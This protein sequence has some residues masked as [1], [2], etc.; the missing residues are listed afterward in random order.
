[1]GDY[2]DTAASELIFPQ[3]KGSTYGY[4]VVGFGSPR[5]RWA[6]PQRC[7]AVM[8]NNPNLLFKTTTAGEATDISQ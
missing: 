6:A 8:Y 7:G 5:P 1:M 4:L 3:P 2:I